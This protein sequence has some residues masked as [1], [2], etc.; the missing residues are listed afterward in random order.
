MVQESANNVFAVLLAMSTGNS[1]IG[2]TSNR[3]NYTTSASPT[4]RSRSLGSLRIVHSGEFPDE[5]SADG[6]VGHSLPQL[7]A[8]HLSGEVQGQMLPKILPAS[9]QAQWPTSGPVCEGLALPLLNMPSHHPG[10]SAKHGHQRTSS[11]GGG[12]RDLKEGSSDD[13][14][15]A[16]KLSVQPRERRQ[17][18]KEGQSYVG[19]DFYRG[20]MHMG[21]ITYEVCL[22]ALM[23]ASIALLFYYAFQLQPNKA[24]TERSPVDWHPIG[25]NWMKGGFCVTRI[26]CHAYL[27]AAGGEQQGLETLKGVEQLRIWDSRGV[28]LGSSQKIVPPVTQ[29]PLLAAVLSSFWLLIL[30][31]KVTFILALQALLK[32]NDPLSAKLLLINYPV[33]PDYWSCNPICII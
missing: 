7:S 21:W 8:L 19:G 33:Q 23:L 26:Q 6:A 16:S 27:C 29:P 31:V 10:Y 30:Y 5:L 17:R 13:S 24:P 32:C 11:D 12:T 4:K 9:L 14:G 15:I 25:A 20:T 1:V 28:V 3:F 18:G 22:C 2:M